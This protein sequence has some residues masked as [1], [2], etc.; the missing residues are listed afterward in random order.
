[1][2]YSLRNTHL[3]SC[4]AHKAIQDVT[5]DAG[6]I[7]CDDIEHIYTKRFQ[8]FLTLADGSCENGQCEKGFPHTR[9]M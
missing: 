5:K 6:I 1:M 2:N 8:S 3:A 4:N 9:P 7:R